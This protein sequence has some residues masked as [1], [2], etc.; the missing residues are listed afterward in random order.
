MAAFDFGRTAVFERLG[1]KNMITVKNISPVEGIIYMQMKNND[2][3]ICEATAR[4]QGE[5]AELMDIREYKKGFAYDMGKAI[6]NSIDLK[7]IKKVECSNKNLH[8]VLLAL[9]FSL[10]NC[11]YSLTL[12]G[13]FDT[14]C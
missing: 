2:V 5:T 8:D 14:K 4:L 10:S 7:G 11:L 9:R 1:E 12:D 13:Y 6:L 3:L